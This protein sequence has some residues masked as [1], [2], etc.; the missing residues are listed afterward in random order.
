MRAIIERLI[1]EEGRLPVHAANSTPTA[2]LYAAGL[3]PYCAVRVLLA[4]ER[5]FNVV[6][7]REALTRETLGS[8]EAIAEAVRR[9]GCL[10]AA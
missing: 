6:F 1:D 10:A 7:P 3:T 2:D 9:A 8:L 4:L 5:E